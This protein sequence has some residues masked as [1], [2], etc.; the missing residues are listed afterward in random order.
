MTTAHLV[1]E[2]VT[3]CAATDAPDPSTSTVSTH[4]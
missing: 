3:W 1:A 4:P 2:M